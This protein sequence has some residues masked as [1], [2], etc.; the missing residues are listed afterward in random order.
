MRPHM[1]RGTLVL[2]V[3]L[4][5]SA[6]LLFPKV[7]GAADAHALDSFYIVENVF[8]DDLSSGYDEILEVRPQEKNVCV[9]LIRISLASR[10][11]G[12]QLVRGVEQV[13]PNTTVRKIAG[14][15]DPCS[16]SE[17]EVQT[18]IKQAAPR[19]VQTVM[20]SA[21]LNIVAKCGAEEK[22]FGFPYPEE[23]DL[24]KLRHRTPRVNT[25]WDLYYQIRSKTFGK[26]F[27]FQNLSVEEEKKREEKG[28]EL[29]RELV[30]GK[31][32]TGFAGYSC[33]TQNCEGNYLAWRLKGYAGPP[34]IRDSSVELVNADAL[35]LAHYDLPQYPVLAMHTRVSGEVRLRILIDSQTGVVKNAQQVSG[36][37]LLGQFAI[38]AAKKW[39]FSPQGQTADSVEAVLK[40][41]L[42]PNDN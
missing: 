22:V 14:Q 26:Q 21:I 25:L 12:G 8:S 28:T 32:Q 15:T 9:R 16:Y 42:C 23:V 33:G 18:A 39:R 11:C 40:F 1:L 41:A 36:S 34:A 31:F 13:L 24:Q 38:D 2:V 6:F 37:T 27:S 20:D 4:G 3:I 10:F 17:S 7:E 19:G 29:I 5:C 30:S 35:H